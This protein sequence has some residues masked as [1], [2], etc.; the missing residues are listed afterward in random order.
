MFGVAM[1]FEIFVIIPS[2]VM[3]EIAWCVGFAV[4]LTCLVVLFAVAVGVVGLC[5]RRA[6]RQHLSRPD[7]T[8]A[9]PP[10]PA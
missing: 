7:H 10:A 9:P 4:A 3:A 5:G 6:E 2:L 8:R 1:L